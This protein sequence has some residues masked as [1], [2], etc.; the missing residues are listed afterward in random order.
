MFKSFVVALAT[1][2]CTQFAFADSSSI[3]NALSGNGAGATWSGN[4]SRTGYGSDFFSGAN[5]QPAMY[6]IKTVG[7]LDS[8]GLNAMNIRFGMDGNLLSYTYRRALVNENFE[9][10]HL[11]CNG[12]RS[13]QRRVVFKDQIDE[14]KAEYVNGSTRFDQFQM[15]KAIG[16]LDSGAFPAVIIGKR[17]E[18][19]RVI[20]ASSTDDALVIPVLSVSIE[21]YGS[22]VLLM[23]AFLGTN[24]GYAG[25]K[26]Q[27][28]NH[29]ARSKYIMVKQ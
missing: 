2:L 23:T 9:T 3:I 13:V 21:D 20:N 5:V 27:N 26:P 7:D 18:N 19:G 12:G 17:C 29:A 25:W 4:G 8:F 1:I 22:P 10:D 11:N 15:Q 24:K 14:L 6:D 16:A 28:A